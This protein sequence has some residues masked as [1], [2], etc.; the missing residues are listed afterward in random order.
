MKHLSYLLLLIMI[1]CAQQT[2]L[3]GGDKDV[4]APQLIMGKDSIPTIITNFKGQN[5]TFEFNENVQFLKGKRAIITNPK[6]NEID[7]RI[8]KKQLSIY[9]EDTLKENTTYSFLFKESIADLTEKNKIPLFKHTLSTGSFIDTGLVNGTVINSP[10]FSPADNFL[11]R[12][13][14]LEINHQEYIGFTNKNGRFTIENIKAGKYQLVTFD[15]ENKNFELDT[16]KETQGFF[17]DTIEVVDTVKNIQI[18]SFQP[19]KKTSIEKTNLN[20]VGV[21]TIEFNVPVD[22]CIIVDTIHNKKYISN[23]L[24]KKHLFYFSDSAEKYVIAINSN[25]SEFYDTIRVAVDN[26]KKQ[27][28]TISYKKNNEP[29]L[30][31]AENITLVFNQYIKAVDTSLMQLKKDSNSVKYTF[32]FSSNKLQIKPTVGEGDY[33]LTFLPKSLVGNKNTKSDTSTVNFTIKST[34]DLA[35]L[36]L[37]LQEIP[38]KKSIVQLYQKGMLKKEFACNA[39]KLD[40]LITRCIPGDY[41][42]KLIA[43]NDENGYWTTGDMK[44]QKLPEKIHVY[45]GNVSLKKNWTSTI[46]WLFTLPK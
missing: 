45:D 5:L 37:I 21:L 46:T 13:K 40:T 27:I 12:L 25:S 26:G 28:E 19:K 39:N 16:L 7:V 35:E 42:L 24:D 8:E 6:I 29:S 1:S 38:I 14:N 36:A 34:K 17:L 31:S 20:N 41:E 10:D 15:D 44:S 32:S 22:S 23:G 4:L 3:T 18:F 9:W 11:I 33:Q 30:T 43:D 2:V